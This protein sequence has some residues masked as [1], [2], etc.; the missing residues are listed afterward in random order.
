MHEYLGSMPNARK[1]KKA[2]TKRDLTLLSLLGS[3]EKEIGN[4]FI[5]KDC[6]GSGPQCSNDNGEMG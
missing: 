1:N 3:A 2:T 6:P 4:L 5:N